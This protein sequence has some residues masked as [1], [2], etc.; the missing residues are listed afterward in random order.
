MCRTHESEASLFDQ[1]LLL[2]HVLRHIHEVAQQR[3][4]RLTRLGQPAQP[5][6]VLGDHQEVHGALTQQES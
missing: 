6:T 2:G 1:P 3:L 4:V 5:L